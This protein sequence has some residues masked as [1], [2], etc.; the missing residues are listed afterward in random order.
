MQKKNK[1]FVDIN[2]KLAKK[3]GYTASPQPPIATLL[4]N[5]P[6]PNPNDVLTNKQNKVDPELKRE[7]FKGWL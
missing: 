7:K 6:R 3:R 2:K 4:V 1:A 5:K